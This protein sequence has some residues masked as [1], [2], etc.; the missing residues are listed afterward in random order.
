LASIY[1]T[2]S[3]EVRLINGDGAPWIKGIVSEQEDAYYQLDPFHRSKAIT[4]AVLDKKERK[5]AIN[6]FNEGKVKEGLE[7]LTTLLIKYNDDEKQFKK[8]SDLYNYLVSNKSGLMPYKLRND[9]N[10]PKPPEGIEYRGMGTMESNIWSELARRLKHIRAS[11]S[12]KGANNLANILTEKI[13]GIIDETVCKFYKN[14]VPE[15]ALNKFE[16][17][18]ILSAKNVTNRSNISVNSQIKSCDMPYDGC[19]ITEGRKVIR[20]LVRNRTFNNLGF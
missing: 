15:D 20:D 14:V 8:L 10:L 12:E 16:D 1:D 6:L 7:Y 2:D 11:W 5:K 3:I 18:V 19:A 17:I 9:V 4:R 13:S